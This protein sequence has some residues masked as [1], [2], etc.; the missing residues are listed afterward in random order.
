[1]VFTVYLNVGTHAVP[2]SL[3]H[4]IYINDHPELQELLFS[5]FYSEAPRLDLLCLQ[6]SM[7]KEEEEDRRNRC[8]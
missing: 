6:P 1:M 5:L 8:G 3:S 4:S 2:P 7:K